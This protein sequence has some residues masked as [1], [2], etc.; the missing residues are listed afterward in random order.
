MSVK[1]Q[2]YYKLLGVKRSAT[3]KEIRAAYRKLARKQHPDIYPV[4][5]KK[6]SRGKI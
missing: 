1:F 2:D 5:E 4:N 6:R 3:D